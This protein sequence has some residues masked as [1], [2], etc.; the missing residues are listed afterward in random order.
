M[1]TLLQQKWLS[2]LL[3]Y[4]YI[5]L[6]KK[7]VDNVAAV[8]LS[9][10]FEDQSSCNVVSSFQPTWLHKLMLS[11][12]GDHKAQSLI[13]RF[14]LAPNNILGFSWHLHTL[15]F[16]GCLY[17]GSTGSLRLNIW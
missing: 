5:I 2:R 11:W 13:A 17:V 16:K 1:T 6:Y 4:D 9:R 12:E 10:A 7:G 8:S 14:L 3:G 15:H